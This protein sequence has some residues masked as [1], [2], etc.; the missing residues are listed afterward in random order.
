MVAE[1]G[2]GPLRALEKGTSA[3]VAQPGSGSS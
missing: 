3:V 2:R 1:P